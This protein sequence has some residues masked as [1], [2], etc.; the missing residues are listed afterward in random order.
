MKPNSST[1]WDFLLSH[2][3]ASRTF[4][5]GYDNFGSNSNCSS[6]SSEGDLQSPTARK[7]TWLPNITVDSGN[8][9]T[10]SVTSDDNISRVNV[11]IPGP[12]ENRSADNM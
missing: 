12:R 3:V 7:T 11:P 9:D 2:T 1:V 8:F 6:V 4:R 5:R 10:N